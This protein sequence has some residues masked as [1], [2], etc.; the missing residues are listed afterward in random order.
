MTH[1][2]LVLNYNLGLT[3][4]DRSDESEIS[5]ITYLKRGNK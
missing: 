3:H 5:C 4:D 2:A 1:L